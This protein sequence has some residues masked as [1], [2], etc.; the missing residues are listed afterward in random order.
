MHVPDIDGQKFGAEL[1]TSLRKSKE[2][3]IAG[4]PVRWAGTNAFEFAY[5]WGRKKETRDVVVG[6]HSLVIYA[7]TY[8]YDS[9]ISAQ[10]SKSAT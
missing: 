9:T 5:G 6:A 1:A 2:D 3:A 10:L 4:S 7:V 8:F